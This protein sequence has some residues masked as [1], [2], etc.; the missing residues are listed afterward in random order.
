MMS[1]T[2]SCKRK[3][4]RLT[5]KNIQ[6]GSYESRVLGIALLRDL[7]ACFI[8]EIFV[9]YKPTGSQTCGGRNIINIR[10][11]KTTMMFNTW[12]F[13]IAFCLTT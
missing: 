4:Y 13:L 3:I 8:W 9:F 12:S 11:L 2:R 7:K 5:N 6:L 10:L 1:Q